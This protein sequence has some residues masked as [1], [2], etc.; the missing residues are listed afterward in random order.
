M[1]EPVISYWDL[2]PDISNYTN[3][4]LSDI[5]ILCLSYTAFPTRSVIHLMT[6]GVIV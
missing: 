6:S 3:W 1:Q 2:Q 5:R 4:L